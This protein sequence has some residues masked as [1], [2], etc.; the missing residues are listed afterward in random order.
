MTTISPA[1][2]SPPSGSRHRTPAVQLV[3]GPA[4]D[5][6]SSTSVAKALA[7]LSCF[8]PNR[9]AMG[10]SEIA[11]Q[12]HLPKSTAHRLLAVLVDWDMVTKRGTEYSPGA[13]LN[14]LAAL[15]TQPDNHE[16]RRVT[17]PHLLDLY[18]MTHETVNLGVLTGHDVLYI[19]KIHGH[20]G[21]NSPACVGGRLPAANTAIGKALLAFGDQDII[22]RVSANLRPAT[23]LSVS[24]PSQLSRELAAITRYGV[25]YD[26]QESRPGLT[27][28]AAPVRSWSGGVVA[29]ISISGPVHR[30]RP[31]EAAPAIRAAAAGIARHVQEVAWRRATR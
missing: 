3:A 4:L 14:E 12:A 26:R 16:L 20:N 13:R 18:E 21:V 8:T 25:A 19:D 27:C 23:S 1:V 6:D 29:A 28:I 10:V 11:R 9:P 22:A 17:L 7:L 24:S 31:A 2:V 30:F 5:P 15:G